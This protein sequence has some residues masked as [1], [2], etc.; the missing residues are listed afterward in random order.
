[1]S[2]WPCGWNQKNCQTFN[3][4]I[5]PRNHNSTYSGVKRIVIRLQ[6]TCRRPPQD[7]V[8]TLDCP[9]T[10]PGLAYISWS[11]CA[12]DLGDRH[13]SGSTVLP[14]MRPG[15]VSKCPH[16]ETQGSFERQAA[17]K[18]WLPET[19]RSF[20][21]SLA[22]PQQTHSGNTISSG[23]STKRR[24]SF[25]FST[26]MQG[27]INGQGPGSLFTGGPFFIS[28]YDTRNNVFHFHN[29][30]RNSYDVTTSKHVNWST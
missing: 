25:R 28:Y 15:V 9:F 27:R 5:I 30:R 3:G 12:S 19:G 10:S 21:C 6:G 7:R 22:F 8:L 24:L 16:Q 1:M 13:W 11:A 20:Q 29:V 23:L 17:H 2:C 26:C 18:F 14:N 4:T